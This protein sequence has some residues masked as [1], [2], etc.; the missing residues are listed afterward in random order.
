MKT[1]L[2]L[3]F[4]AISFSVRAAEDDAK[5]YQDISD[6][7]FAAEGKRFDAYGKADREF[8]TEI[9]KTFQFADR[10]D[11]FLLDHS[12]GKDAAYKPKGRE[13]AFPI[14]PYNKETKILKTGSVAPKDIAKWTAA[15]RKTLM[16]DKEAGG[17][18]CHFPIH[19]LRVYARNKLL[20]ETSLCWHCHNYYFEDDWVS[21][22]ADAKELRMLI[23]AL[24]PIPEE[25]RARFPG[26]KAKDK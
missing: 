1:I 11:V 13:E 17:A 18:L 24:M 25:E 6:I 9:A 16:S 8:R 10:I 4:A 21:L 22:T 14:R 20:F 19:G 3:L 7:R 12:I 26:A 23:E 2:S 5:I 15:L